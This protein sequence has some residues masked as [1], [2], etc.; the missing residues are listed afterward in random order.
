ME[1]RL[2]SLR[3]DWRGFGY[4]VVGSIVTMPGLP[5]TPVKAG[6]GECPIT[7]ERTTEGS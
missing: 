6:D 3:V 7:S 1:T 2:A 5:L 4:P